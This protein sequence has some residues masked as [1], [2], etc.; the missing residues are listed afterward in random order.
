MSGRILIADSVATN[1]ILMNM[2][3]SGASYDVMQAETGAEVLL[4]ATQNPPDLFVISDTLQDLDSVQVC[5]ALRANPTTCDVPIITITTTS[6]NE[7]RLA[8]IQAGADE[9]LVKPVDDKILLARVRNLLRRRVAQQEQLLRR[10]TALELGFNEPP[11]NF[12]PKSRV[13]IVATDQKTADHWF[14]LLANKISGSLTPT[15][16]DRLLKLTS[17]PNSSPDLIIL[18]ADNETGLTLLAELRSRSETRNSAIIVIHPVDDRQTAVSAMDMGAD[19][20]LQPDCTP[21]EMALRS[22]RQLARKLQADHLRNSIESDLKLAMIDPL[23]GLY[24]RRYALP[25]LSRVSSRAEESQRPFAVMILDLDRFKRIN[26]VH[27][28]AAGD[29]VLVEIANRIKSNL[30]SVD[31]VARIGGEEFL[32]V[33]PDTNQTE[34]RATAERL[35]RV[36]ATEPISIASQSEGINV[37]LSIGFSIGG[38]NQPLGGG[39]C[40]P[41]WNRQIAHYWKQNQSGEIR[42]SLAR[43]PHNCASSTLGNP[44]IEIVVTWTCR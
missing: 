21:T 30:R 32:I 2:K 8:S 26:D 5:K 44:L 7:D 37:T 9:V 39:Q 31:L 40:N 22:N 25:H 28:H 19:D 38:Q 34:A 35:R 33:M 10:G 4:L 36:T 29:S 27:G 3:L 20:L 13:M 18:T 17:K 14:G 12:S 15:T 41:L 24:N 6:D 11:Q 42:S 16:S 1:R 23:T 43:L